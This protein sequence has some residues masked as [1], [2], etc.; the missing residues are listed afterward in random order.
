MKLQR[1]LGDLEKKGPDGQYE[2]AYMESVF[3]VDEATKG[4]LSAEASQIREIGSKQF[5]VIIREPV[6]RIVK[7]PTSNTLGKGFQEMFY[8]LQAKGVE[9]VV[10]P[11]M[12]ALG[13][14]S[15]LLQHDPRS[16]VVFMLNKES[17]I[18][19]SSTNYEEW[20][21]VQDL[22][23]N[24]ETFFRAIG[25]I[26]KSIANIAEKESAKHPLTK[27]EKRRLEIARKLPHTVGEV[28]A[29]EGGMAR[30]LSNKGFKEIVLNKSILKELSF[31]IAKWGEA[32]GYNWILAYQKI[33]VDPLNPR[34]IIIP[35]KA[36]A[37][38]A[39]DATAIYYVSVTIGNAAA[40]TIASP[41]LVY[42]YFH[43]DP[44]ETDPTR[45]EKQH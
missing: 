25:P 10:N 38:T 22:F 13:S 24:Q 23:V 17:M 28:R 27:L 2:A 12:S 1:I 43:S 7:P 26:P 30:I 19:N 42:Q 15:V 33:W 45:S 29:K 37:E 6:V 31:Y 34:N 3:R 16:K 5:E 4:M 39:A 44:T 32:A 21:H 40:Y 36:A 11:N 18:R 35:I 20:K 14:V 41:F 9:S 8:D